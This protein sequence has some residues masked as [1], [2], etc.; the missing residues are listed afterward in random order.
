M[1]ASAICCSSLATRAASTGARFVLLGEMAAGAAVCARS[2]GQHI[3]NHNIRQTANRFRIKT[4]PVVVAF[5]EANLT[6]AVV[7]RKSKL[8]IAGIRNCYDGGGGAGGG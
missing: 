4:A 2:T 7:E 3:A 5:K 8:F 6:C 1:R